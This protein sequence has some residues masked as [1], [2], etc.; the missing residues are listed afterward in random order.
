[1]AKGNTAALAKW[2]KH[3]ESCRKAN[4]TKSLKQ[5]MQIAKSTY[6]K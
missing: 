1:M 6:K 2:R 4:P 5:C 3:L